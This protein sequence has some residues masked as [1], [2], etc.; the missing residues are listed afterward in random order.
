MLVIVDHMHFPV[1]WVSVG[2]LADVA[3]VFGGGERLD[4]RVCFCVSVVLQ[5]LVCCGCARLFCGAP[6]GG[7]QA[8]R[9][10]E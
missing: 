1:Q 2:A 7:P 3:F 8:P 6:T 4:G 9:D 5:A 10:K